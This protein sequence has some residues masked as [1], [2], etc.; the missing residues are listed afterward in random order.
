MDYVHGGEVM[1]EVWHEATLQD[2]SIQPME[3]LPIFIINLQQNKGRDFSEE[4]RD[5][6][7]IMKRGLFDIFGID[8]RNALILLFRMGYSKPASA[9]SMRRSIDSFLLNSTGVAN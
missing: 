4:Q 2:L 3:A 9:K 1:Q 5:R 6:L 8:D 7:E